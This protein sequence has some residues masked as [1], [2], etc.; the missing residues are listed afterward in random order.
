MRLERAKVLRDGRMG[1]VQVTRSG[2]QGV[3]ARQGF[4]GAER[5]QRWDSG[6]VHPF[7]VSKTYNFESLETRLNP[8]NPAWSFHATRKGETPCWVS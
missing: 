2:G 6:P 1:H 4:E 5:G 8:S 3:V 7:T